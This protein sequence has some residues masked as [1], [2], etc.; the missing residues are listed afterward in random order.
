MNEREREITLD[1]EANNGKAVRQRRVRPETIKF[2][3]GISLTQPVCHL[4]ETNREDLVRDCP[5]NNTARP[6]QTHSENN[7]D[8]QP[9]SAK[10]GEMQL[11]RQT[12][13][14]GNDDVK[15]DH[16][17]DEYDTDY[18]RELLPVSDHGY[19]TVFLHAGTTRSRRIVRDL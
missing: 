1:W 18:D 5:A 10:G 14:Q 4:I 6:F 15:S 7:N 19:E 17:T 11:E 9:D 16:Q 2:K 3:V 13:Q 12:S 8:K